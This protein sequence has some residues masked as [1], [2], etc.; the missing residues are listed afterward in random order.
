MQGFLYNLNMNI[1]K[2]FINLF[3]QEKIISK[4]PEEKHIEQTG[5]IVQIPSST[6]WFLKGNEK[7][8]IIPID[9]NKYVPIGENQNVKFVFDTG[10]CATFSALNSLETQLKLTNL[11]DE[12]KLFLQKNGY[13]KNGEINFS[14]KF[15]AIV[16]GTTKQGNTFQNVG[17]SIRHDG[18]LPDSLLPFGNE[19]T[20]EDWHNPNQITN[21]HIQ[22]AKEF[23]S[24]F[25]VTYYFVVFNNDGNLTDEELSLIQQALNTAPVQIAIPFPATHATLLL[26]INKDNYTIYDTY[27][28]FIFKKDKTIGIHYGAQYSIVPKKVQSKPRTLRLG[29]RGIDVSELQIEL[30][31]QQDG[32]F[33]KKTESA[34]KIYQKKN[35]LTSDGIFGEKTRSKLYAKKYMEPT[36]VITRE[37]STK[38]QTLGTLKAMNG[39]QVMYCKTLELPWLD[40]KPNVSCIPKGVYQVKWT[41]SKLF[42]KYTYEVQDVP[43]RTGIRFH[44]GNT[45]KDILGCLLLGM[46]FGDVNKDGILDVVSSRDTIAKFEKFFNKKPFTLHIV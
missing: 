24:Y 8:N 7:P 44:P 22:L 30:K 42:K 45:Y 34:V 32:V 16:S 40:N 17:N 35:G 14:D 3:S 15:T 9:W 13:Y 37:E 4:L 21:Y 29:D 38:K 18:L 28:P 36:V 25:D 46:D 31:I 12:H 27:D 5:L 10:S 11:P 41:Y 33:G 39:D 19:K 20:W 1:L 2:W 6:D 23:S 43:D 26:E